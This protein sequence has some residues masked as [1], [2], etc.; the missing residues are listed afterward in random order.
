MRKAHRHNR[1]RGYL[2]FRQ[3]RRIAVTEGCVRQIYLRKNQD[4]HEQAESSRGATQAANPQR[5]P[6]EARG[7]KTVRYLTLA[8]GSNHSRN[9]GGIV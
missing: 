1:G 7:R 8:R 2:Q 3:D 6:P 9:P 4:H 5:N